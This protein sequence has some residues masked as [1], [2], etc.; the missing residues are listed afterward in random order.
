MCSGKTNPVWIE[1]IQEDMVSVQ[2]DVSYV[3]IQKAAQRRS[4]VNITIF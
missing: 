3:V 4:G 1:S 2:S